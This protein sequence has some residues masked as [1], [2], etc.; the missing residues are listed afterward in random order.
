MLLLQKADLVPFFPLFS[1]LLPSLQLPFL[2]VM[3]NYLYNIS[4][5]SKFALASARKVL[6]NEL[7][8]FCIMY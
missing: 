1:V 8:V 3:Y 5:F 2:R 7:Y 4:K 6:Y